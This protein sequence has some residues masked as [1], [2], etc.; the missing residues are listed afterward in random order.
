MVF[1]WLL[2]QIIML[3]RIRIIFQFFIICYLGSGCAFKKPDITNQHVFVLTPRDNLKSELERIALTYKSNVTVELL[4]GIYFID[5]QILLENVDNFILKGNRSVIKMTDNSPVENNYGILSFKQSTN[6]TLE[7]IIFNGNRKKRVCRETAAHTLMIVSSRNVFLKEVSC[8]D[9]AVDGIIIYSLNPLDSNFHCK[10]IFIN[11]CQILNSYRNGI[12]IIEGNGVT[13]SNSIVSNSNGTSPESG[14]VVESDYDLL[15]S[16]IRNISI[17]NVFFNQNNGWGVIISQKGQPSNTIISD[18]RISNSGKGGIW[19][20]SSTTSIQGCKFTNNG[21]VGI[22]SVRYEGRYKD[23]TL[24]ESNVIK[25]EKCGI[26][27]LGYGGRIISNEIDTIF[28]QG[29]YLNGRTTDSTS[30]LIEGNLIKNSNHVLIEVNGFSRGLIEN[31]TL[32]EGKNLGLRAVNS[33]IYLHNNTFKNIHSAIDA[34]Y[35]K[36]GLQSNVFDRCVKKI[37]EGS[38]VKYIYKN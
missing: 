34:E 9:N 16:G 7:N 2:V 3:Q 31:N 6:V 17:N 11:N 21:D 5:K 18:C 24:I 28:D 22:R 12:S 8:L 26:D 20:C 27:Y 38:N 19:N 13:I 36:M 33:N 35:S 14:I 15:P 25:H 1:Y 10:N 4:Q 29:I 32:A 37:I 30:V 23:F